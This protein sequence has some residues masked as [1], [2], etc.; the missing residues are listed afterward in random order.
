MCTFPSGFRWWC[1]WSVFRAF[2]LMCLSNNYLL[3]KGVARRW[4]HPPVGRATLG[5]VPQ[6]LSEMRRE[7]L[8]GRERVVRPG[9]EGRGVVGLVCERHLRCSLTLIFNSAPVI[10]VFNGEEDT[11][12]KLV[13]LENLPTPTLRSELILCSRHFRNI[14]HLRCPRETVILAGFR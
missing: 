1:I 14:Y 12:T 10:K 13:P 8:Q 2:G 11:N 9:P 3:R 6:L 4:D 5:R 7:G